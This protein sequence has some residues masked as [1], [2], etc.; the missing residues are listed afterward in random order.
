MESIKRASNLIEVK[1]FDCVYLCAYVSIGSIRVWPQNHASSWS[2]VAVYL[3]T[4]AALPDFTLN[5][6]KIFISRSW[7][8]HSDNFESEMLSFLHYWWFS[9]WLRRFKKKIIDFVYVFFKDYLGPR[10]GK[11]K[12][13]C[14][15]VWYSLVDKIGHALSVFTSSVFLGSWGCPIVRTLV[16]NIVS[17]YC[18]NLALQKLVSSSSFWIRTEKT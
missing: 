5:L 17:S 18:R 4:F 14:Q 8:L 9:F 2:C 12:I 10:Y 6:Q 13:W 15:K 1:M 16:R 3:L 11:C 7:G